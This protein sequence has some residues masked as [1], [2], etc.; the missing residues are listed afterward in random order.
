MKSLIIVQVAW[1]VLSQPQLQQLQQREQQRAELMLL[2]PPSPLQLNFIYDQATE[3]PVKLADR[4]SDR[5]HRLAF[6]GR[7]SLSDAA[8][9]HR[10]VPKP[11][12]SLA[13]AS[14]LCFSSPFDRQ[15]PHANCHGLE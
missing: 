9:D 3:T 14:V 13:S 8:A 12:S 5:Q 1:S 6:H 15:L 2:L 11:P 7:S 4:V 10:P